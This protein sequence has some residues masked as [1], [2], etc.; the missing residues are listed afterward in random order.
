MK[1]KF[2]QVKVKYDR[3]GNEGHFTTVTETY[4]VDAMSFTEAEKRITEE[5]KEFVSGEFEVVGIR[6]TSI[7]ELFANNEGDIW[8]KFKVAFVVLDEERGIEK[9]TPHFMLAQG[10]NLKEALKVLE[11]GMEGTTTNYDVIS[12]TET[13]IMD[14]LKLE[15]L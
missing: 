1:N 2:Y 3:S 5:L 9:R 7:T 10:E 4:L 12:V 15:S 11:K 14:V 8:Y 13:P 6:G